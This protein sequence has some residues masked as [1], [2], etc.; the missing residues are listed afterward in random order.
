MDRNIELVYYVET[1]KIEPAQICSWNFSKHTSIGK[2]YISI[3][4][5]H[6]DLSQWINQVPIVEFEK[7]GLPGSHISLLTWG[8]RT[9]CDWDPIYAKFD[10]TVLAVDPTGLLSATYHPSCIWVSFVG[11]SRLQNERCNQLHHQVDNPLPWPL[12]VPRKWRPP[13]WVGYNIWFLKK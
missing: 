3:R 7:Y 1:T 4:I 12:V 2:T 5:E 11:L 8:V 9:I 13:F 10:G 6:A